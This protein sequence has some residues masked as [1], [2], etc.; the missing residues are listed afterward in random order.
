MTG[1]EG[2][3]C[4]CRNPL[5]FGGLRWCGRGEV[6]YVRVCICVCVGAWA[7]R[8]PA[9]RTRVSCLPALPG[10]PPHL[11]PGPSEPPSQKD[12]P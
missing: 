7:R 5:K 11:C 8:Q 12:W 6:V 9:A 3:S 10:W 2:G 1:G 4:P